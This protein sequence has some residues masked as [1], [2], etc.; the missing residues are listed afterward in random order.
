LARPLEVEDVATGL[1][2]GDLGPARHRD[3]LKILDLPIQGE[4]PGHAQHNADQPDSQHA[5]S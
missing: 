2:E 3:S 1:R 4:K 5:A